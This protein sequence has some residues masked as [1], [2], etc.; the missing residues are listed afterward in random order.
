MTSYRLF[1]V[2]SALARF[3]RALAYYWLTLRSALRTLWASYRFTLVRYRVRA[4]TSATGRSLVRLPRKAGSL[5]G[6]IAWFLGQ[7][8]PYLSRVLEERREDRAELRAERR[9]LAAARRAQRAER[10]ELRQARVAE[11]RARRRAEHAEIKAGR[12]KRPHHLPVPAWISRIERPQRPAAATALRRL[13][14]PRLAMVAAAITLAA[15]VPTYAIVTGAVG[16]EPTRA[17]PQ[18]AGASGAVIPGAATPAVVPGQ[19]AA[20]TPPTTGPTAGPAAP[21]PVT[22]DTAEFVRTLPPLPTAAP[23]VPA[24]R[25]RVS[26]AAPAGAPAASEASVVGSLSKPL[27]E[28]QQREAR[29][30][31]KW[32]IKQERAK[33]Q[34]AK[35]DLGK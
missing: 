27:S 28:H 22:G 25:L 13:P 34:P 4:A 2:R 26:A 35:T 7:L 23:T 21:G 18:V 20:P 15:V 29:R 8:P 24:P 6:L 14:A 10:R 33:Q 31:A 19:P 16:S 17:T 32:E 5:L 11:R 12:E 9:L 1:L 3:G 30:Q